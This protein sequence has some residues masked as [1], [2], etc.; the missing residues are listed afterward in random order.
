MAFSI[1]VYSDSKTAFQS[2]NPAI[3]LKA[4]ENFEKLKAL[5]VPGEFLELDKQDNKVFAKN[6][7]TVLTLN[8]S[9]AQLRP[10]RYGLVS[11]NL[12]DYKVNK[13]QSININDL[14]TPTLQKSLEKFRAIIPIKSYFVMQSKDNKISLKEY[15]NANGSYFL[16]PVIYDNWF[17]PDKQIIIQSFSVL[18]GT[19]DGVE[20]P[21][22]LNE[23]SCSLWLNNKIQIQDITH[24]P[25]V[26]TNS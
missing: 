25:L 17:S 20:L 11:S 24:P 15:S 5:Q 18:T 22:E 26:I 2:L 21:F 16:A 10:M 7:T 1:Q 3:N 13:T 6:W 12:D 9:E 4:Y 19:V 14:Q 23:N 8:N